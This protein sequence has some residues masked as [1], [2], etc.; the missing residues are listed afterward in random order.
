MKTICS[1]GEADDSYKEDIINA[2]TRSNDCVGA[3]V[4]NDEVTF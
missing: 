3:N 1:A 2:I 4:G